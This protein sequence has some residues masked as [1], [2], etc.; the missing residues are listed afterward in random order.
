MF[1]KLIDIQT[2]RYHKCIR[3]SWFATQLCAEY[4]FWLKGS[5]MDNIWFMD[6]H[7]ECQWMTSYLHSDWLV[8]SYEQLWLAEVSLCIF[9]IV[10]GVTISLLLP[11]NKLGFSPPWHSA[12]LSYGGVKMG[13]QLEQT[14]QPHIHEILNILN[15]MMKIF[16]LSHCW[17]GLIKEKN[18]RMTMSMTMK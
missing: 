11:D 4:L 1:W 18:F 13:N 2:P 14:Q 15:V 8:I 9:V 17:A 16:C 12:T 10:N 7:K 3:M 6:G 5:C